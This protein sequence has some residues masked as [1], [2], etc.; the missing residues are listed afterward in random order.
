MPEKSYKRHLEK[1][2][3]RT[4][5]KKKLMAWKDLEKEMEQRIRGW[6]YKF[7][8]VSSSREDYP[9]ITVT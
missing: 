2:I 4:S 7:N 6:E 3:F 9:F 8:S 1:Y 5:A